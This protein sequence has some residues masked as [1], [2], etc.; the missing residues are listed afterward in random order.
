GIAMLTLH[1]RTRADGYKGDAEYQ[2]IAKV[3]AAVK[4]P[5]V[6]NGDI[7]T[8][9]KAKYVLQ[10]TGADAIMIGRAAQGRPWIFREIKHFLDTGEHLPPP[11]VTEVAALM[12]RHLREHYAF[13]GEFMGVRTARKH[14][15]W[16]VQDLVGGEV[17]RQRMNLL[18]DC[19]AQ[20]A[21]VKMFFDDRPTERLQYRPFVTE[22]AA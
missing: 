3:K 14:I 21:A 11:L 19:E 17:F 15:G 16:Y 5:V 12:D 13:Y 6:A 8:P 22:L 2:T 18:E 1:G 10:V 4:I 7:S 20:L 9:E